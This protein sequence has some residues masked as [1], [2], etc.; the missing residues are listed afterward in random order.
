M[1]LLRQK[2]KSHG[3]RATLLRGIIDDMFQT[4]SEGKVEQTNE[5]RNRAEMCL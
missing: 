5:N 3:D 2:A 4:D 1:N